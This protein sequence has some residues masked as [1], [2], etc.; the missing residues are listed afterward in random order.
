[1]KV[2]GE[3]QTFRRFS[4]IPRRKPHIAGKLQFSVETRLLGSH[5]VECAENASCSVVLCRAV[6]CCVVRCRADVSCGVVRCRAVS[7]RGT[8]IA[9]G[10]GAGDPLTFFP[11]SRRKSMKINRNPQNQ[12]KCMK[13]TKNGEERRKSANALKTGDPGGKHRKTKIIGGHRQNL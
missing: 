2:C 4:N 3:L 11:Q 10:H 7:C 5:K 1:M 6:S 9:P 12:R 13:P 8:N